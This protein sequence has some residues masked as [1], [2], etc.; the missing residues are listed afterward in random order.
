MSLIELLDKIASDVLRELRPHEGLEMK[1]PVQTTQ[2]IVKRRAYH[3]LLSLSVLVRDSL[4]MNY[5]AIGLILR[6]IATDFIT[7]G[8][9]VKSTTDKNEVLERFYRLYYSEFYRLILFT[10]DINSLGLIT[11]EDKEIMDDSYFKSH[12]VLEDI[13]G[14]YN[15]TEPKPFPGVKLMIKEIRNRGDSEK[16]LLELVSSYDFWTFFSKYE[17]LGWHSYSFT[18]KLNNELLENHIRQA[19]MYIMICMIMLDECDIVGDN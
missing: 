13:K 11:K 15:G 6:N 16:Y 2:L 18:R 7:V 9:I 14:Y 3:N 12:K 17:H 19:V 4:V 1:F 10:K 8:Y 5:Q